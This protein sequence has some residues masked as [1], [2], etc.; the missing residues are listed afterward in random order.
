MGRALSINNE[1]VYSIDIVKILAMFLVLFLHLIGVGGVLDGA[2][3]N[4][5]LFGTLS[6]L[7]G[8]AFVSVNLF[9]LATGFISVNKNIRYSRLFRLW[10]QAIFICFFCMGIVL[11]A[12]GEIT[13]RN[14]IYSV[15]VLTLKNYWYL[16]EYIAMMLISPVLNL[17]VRKT[18][19]KSM[20]FMVIAFAVIVSF[21]PFVFARE[22]L[23][24]GYSFL[25]LSYLYI[26]GGYINKYGLHK[27]LS[28][29]FVAPIYAVTTLMQG[30]LIFASKKYD[31]IFFGDKDYSHIHSWYNNAFVLISSVTLFIL[32]LGIN[33]KS[34]KLKKFLSVVSAASFSVY[35]VHGSP[36][37]WKYIRRKLGFIGQMNTLSSVLSIIGIAVGIYVASILIGLLQDKIFKLAKIDVLCDKL[38]KFAEK[39]YDSVYKKA[40][41]LLIKNN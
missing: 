26:I 39:I 31:L 2:V 27:K 16:N 6:M 34:D 11:I 25:W 18:D 15:F 14:V 3:D 28:K 21:V 22:T 24:R 41:K 1:R 19:G 7:E 36:A 23:A 32:L 10:L 20:G 33:I 5:L 29:L 9:A 30:V 35:L 38:G 4:T 40:K 12:G 13:G 8:V 17:A 37:V